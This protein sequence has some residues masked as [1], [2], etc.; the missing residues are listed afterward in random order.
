M[1]KIRKALAML[2]VGTALAGS[3]VAGPALA[4]PAVSAL[5]HGHVATQ[6]AEAHDN[7]RA[8]SH[9]DFETSLYWNDYRSGLTFTNS[10]GDVVHQHRWRSTNKWTYTVHDDVYICGWNGQH[11]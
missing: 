9:S 6:S 2:G 7:G 5:T 3:I 1:G 10:F 8:C 4:A 11:F